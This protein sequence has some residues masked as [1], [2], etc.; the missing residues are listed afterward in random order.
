MSSIYKTGAI[1][2]NNGSNIVTGNGTSF[3]GVAGTLAGDLFSVDGVNFY[4]IYQVDSNNQIRIRT[5]PAGLP[6]QQ[7]SKLNSDYAILRNFTSS[8]SAEVAARVVAVQ[9][10]WHLREEEMTGWFAS[11]DDYYNVTS[12]NGD[13]I[14][15]M[16]PAGIANLLGTAATKN[17]GESSGDLMEVGAFGI[18]SENGIGMLGKTSANDINKTGFYYYNNSTLDTPVNNSYGTLLH[19]KLG[20][21]AA[22]QLAITTQGSRVFSRYKANNS[23]DVWVEVYHSGNSVNPLD[24]GIGG[25]KAW[26]N[27]VNLDDLTGT[28]TGIYRQ[29]ITTGGASL[30][31]RYQGVSN[32]NF[33][34]LLMKEAEGRVVQ[35][36]YDAK[37]SSIFHRIFTTAWTPWV[38]V[39]H[40]GNTN[41]NEFGGNGV[42]DR[43]AKGI[44]RGATTAFI[45]LPLN[46]L[47]PAT[48]FSAQGTFRLVNYAGTTTLVSG[49]SSS[50]F[51]LTNTKPSNKLFTLLVTVS[52][53]LTGAE[54]VFLET[55]TASAKITVNF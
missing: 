20:A 19:Q 4:E 26:P 7:S 27:G 29:Y 36:L 51:S 2:V 38:E 39:Y 32:L 30:P 14:S 9:Q 25:Y 5:I 13:I 33:T 31:S 50:D 46:S 44:C 49:I 3:L 6:F 42:D 17:V 53:G 12:I 55:E 41:F 47:T 28:G 43:I 52:G 16:T 23:W 10:K 22:T 15:V 21:N 34:I 48:G 37:S 35:T 11:T 40:S 8:T 18:G 54:T 1:S 45:E 24:Y